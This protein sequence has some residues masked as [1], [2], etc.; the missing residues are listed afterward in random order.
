MGNGPF[1]DGLP[2]KTGGSF[3]GYVNLLEGNI[4]I[5]IS[6]EYLK[7]GHLWATSNSLRQNG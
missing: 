6:L 5:Y 2:I 3:H 1:I 7:W 4:C